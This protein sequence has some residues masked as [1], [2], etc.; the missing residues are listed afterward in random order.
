MTLKMWS[1]LIIVPTRLTKVMHNRVETRSG[2]PGHVLSRSSG[3]HPVYKVS[4]S[5]PDSVLVYVC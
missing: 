3:S 2:H 4:I 1:V 5:D